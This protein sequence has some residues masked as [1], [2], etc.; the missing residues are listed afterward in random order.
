MD[1][2]MVGRQPSTTVNEG[3]DGLSSILVSRGLATL[4]GFALS[5]TLLAIGYDGAL[6]PVVATSGAAR[7][8]DRTR[9]LL[10]RVAELYPTVVMSRRALSDVLNQLDGVP[11]L[12]A[13]NTSGGR[14]AGVQVVSL[15]SAGTRHRGCALQKACT[16]SGC[17][18]AIYVGNHEPPEGCARPEGSCQVLT[19]RV[20]PVRHTKAD[21][22]L[23]SQL[24]ME[25]FLQILVIARDE[26]RVGKLHLV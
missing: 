20:G 2:V 17:D 26:R 21:F 22:V 16:Q 3:P 23:E 6:A 5:N 14:A 13:E 19:I 18:T 25:S 12:S 4:H 9:R 7:M 24:E 1:H 15:P 11:S 8:R 10:A